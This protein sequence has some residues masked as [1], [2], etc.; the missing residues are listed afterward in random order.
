MEEKL[1]NAIKVALEIEDREISLGDNFKEFEEWDSLSRLSLI[2]VIDEEFDVQIE[3][4]LFEDISTV[5]Q[6]MEAIGQK[7][8]AK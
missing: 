3:G 5:A 7:L 4:K 1:L 2:S 6:L 8:S